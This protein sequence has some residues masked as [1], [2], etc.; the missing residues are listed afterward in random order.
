MNGA[1]QAHVSWSE[2]GATRHVVAGNAINA[3]PPDPGVPQVS[4]QLRY[5]ARSIPG[6]ACGRYDGPPLAWVVVACK[7]PDGSYWALQRWQRL[8][9]NYGGKSA[10]L[11][12][13]AL[14]LVGA[15]ARAPGLDGLGVPPLRPS[16]RALHATGASPCTASG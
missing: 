7:A 3:R 10:E 5:G 6:A 4:F 14:P 1:G 16:L 12:A 11:G 2:G 9:P 15:A 8:K 13:P